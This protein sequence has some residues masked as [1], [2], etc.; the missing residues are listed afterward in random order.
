M[1]ALRSLVSSRTVGAIRPS[2]LL[3]SPS[4]RLSAHPTG[5]HISTPLISAR[6]ESQSAF[7][8]FVETLKEQIKKNKELQDSV[9]KLQDESGKVGE[10]DALK[11]AREAFDK[12]KVRLPERKGIQS[13]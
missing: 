2:S 6:Y 12:A 9:K 7:G 10:S 13:N 4:H 3:A 8:K 5:R 11:K 1:S